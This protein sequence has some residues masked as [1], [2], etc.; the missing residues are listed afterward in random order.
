[1][2]NARSQLKSQLMKSLP[3]VAPDR[4]KKKPEMAT[5]EHL[6][7]CTEIPKHLESLL[8]N[9]SPIA[10]GSAVE[11]PSILNNGKRFNPATNALGATDD[12]SAIGENNGAVSK[13]SPN[14]SSISKTDFKPST[15]HLTN[16][17]NTVP[18]HGCRFPNSS[19]ASIGARSRPE[20]GYQSPNMHEYGLRYSLL[21]E[22]DPEHRFSDEV[23]AEALRLRTEQEKTRQILH[24]V[25]LSQIL[26][27]LVREA[28]ELGVSGDF[29][30]LLVDSEI[31]DAERMRHKTTERTTQT[32]IGTNK[33]DEHNETQ[34]E[35]LP[36]TQHQ[37]LPSSNL[38]ALHNLLHSPLH[39][40]LHNLLHSLL[41]QLPLH[42]LPQAHVALPAPSGT[43]KTG[44]SISRVQKAR[45]P[46]VP[47][48]PQMYPVYY[49]VPENQGH[50]DPV[51]TEESDLHS[52]AYLGKNY[53]TVLYQTLPQ[54]V[55][56]PML[57]P[58]QQPPYFYVKSSRQPVGHSKYTAPEFLGKLANLLAPAEMK[59]E[60]QPKR[61]K[62]TKSINFMITTPK[63]PPAKKY[64]K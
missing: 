27:Q 31:G 58:I 62:L 59:E 7:R 1:M 5:V 33:V 51:K 46:P 2:F 24:K 56:A 12:L 14:I 43:L 17:E 60:E 55:A 50:E 52:Q 39:N 23:I 61:R 25:N 40:L 29:I 9:L 54:Y 13:N 53:P 21:Q 63:N 11:V 16:A 32:P 3:S 8:H 48:H 45:L 15:P 38:Q 4:H 18:I 10:Y 19:A 6:P 22:M 47:F 41:H 26:L 30:R 34:L 37:P 64:N 42:Y 28:P 49:A 57:H 36:L 35:K 20:S 44:S